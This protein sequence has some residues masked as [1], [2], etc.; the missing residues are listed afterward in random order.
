MLNQASDLWPNRSTISD[1]ICPSAEHSKAN[2]TSY[3]ETGDATDL[4]HDP[5]H[6]CDAHAQAERLRVLHQSH[7]WRRLD[8][9]ISNGRIATAARGWGWRPYGGSNPHRKHAHFSHNRSQRAN[10]APWFTDQG[11]L[12]MG[13][14]EDIN[15]HN[16]L[17]TLKLHLDISKTTARIMAHITAT[18]K[19]VRGDIAA[20]DRQEEEAAKAERKAE[21]AFLAA[22]ADLAP[23]A[24]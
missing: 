10:T 24:T 12:Q 5:A 6:G 22:M 14:V 21:A 9:I 8:Q 18:Q 16:D 19:A 7:N 13:A 2:P 15:K 3:H 23:P 1:G 4:T 20:L 11:D 17:N